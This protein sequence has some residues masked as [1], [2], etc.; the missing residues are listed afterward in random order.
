[1][2]LL[3]LRC[4]PAPEL[5]QLLLLIGCALAAIA[6]RQPPLALTNAPVL[7]RTQPF[8][9]AA[10]T[11]RPLAHLPKTQLLNYP[12]LRIALVATMATPTVLCSQA[13]QIWQL[14]SVKCRPSL[15]VRAFP[16]ATL[17]DTEL[18]ELILQ[19][20]TTTGAD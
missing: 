13:T 8:L 2:R 10:Q 6:T 15:V 12:S 9:I 16:A 7:L 4:K 18:L 20:A 3:E 17:P 11:C 5:P 1:M 19:R 14:P